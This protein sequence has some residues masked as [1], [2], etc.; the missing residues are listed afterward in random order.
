MN[1]RP[2]G[3]PEREAGE[4]YRT[5][6]ALDPERHRRRAEPGQ[7]TAQSQ[8]AGFR[9]VA[10]TPDTIRTYLDEYLLTGAN[11]FVCAFHFGN[12]P[13]SV[14]ER[15]IELFINEVMPHYRA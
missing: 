14:A 8:G 1:P 9:V 11:Y 7:V 13:E 12:M 2:A 4:E 6:T 5:L 15:T 3:L 10:G